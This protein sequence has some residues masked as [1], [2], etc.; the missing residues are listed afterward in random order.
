MKPPTAAQTF[1]ML[2]EQFVVDGFVTHGQPLLATRP[3]DLVNLVAGLPLLPS[4]GPTDL[5][6]F[7][8][9]QVKG[10]ARIHSVMALCLWMAKEKIDVAAAC[11]ALFESLRVIH[12]QPLYVKDSLDASLMN[13]KMSV[14]GAIR[15]ANSTITVVFM[16][17]ELVAKQS[18]PDVGVFVRR[19]NA[20]AAKSNQIT[21]KCACA[22][23]LMFELTAPGVLQSILGHVSKCGWDA[24]AWT[25]ESLAHKKIFTAYQFPSKSRAW[26]SRVKA[27]A[28]SILLFTQH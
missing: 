22:I 17:K 11:P 24:C 8:L 1:A 7:S 25:N 3:N 14:R 18:I 21:G 19:W 28:D 6:L 15:K 16:V 4:R 13:M 12:Y 27:T 26:L 2:T 9:G 23:K 20:M 5:K 10:I